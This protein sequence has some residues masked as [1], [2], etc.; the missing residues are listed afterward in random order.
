MQ[1][2]I[3]TIGRHPVIINSYERKIT[4]AEASAAGLVTPENGMPVKEKFES[5]TMYFEDDKGL[6]TQVIIPS[7]IFYSMKNAVFA[8]E[9]IAPRIEMEFDL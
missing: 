3:G 7:H 5:F 4:D 6:I 2:I 1:K 8:I 9:Q